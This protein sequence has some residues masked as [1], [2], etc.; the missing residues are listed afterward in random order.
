MDTRRKLVIGSQVFL[1]LSQNSRN[2]IVDL[3]RTAREL[4]NC[5]G[6]RPRTLFANDQISAVLA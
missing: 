1:P 4:R 3:V 5:R 2:L 6:G